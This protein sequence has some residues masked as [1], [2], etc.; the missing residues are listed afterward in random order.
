MSSASDRLRFCFF[1]LT[2][3]AIVLKKKTLEQSAPAA[4]RRGLIVVSGSSSVAHIITLRAPIV[5][6]FASPSGQSAPVVTHAVSETVAKLLPEPGLPLR[7][8][9][10]PTGS[11]FFQSHSTGRSTTSHALTTTISDATPFLSFEELNTKSFDGPA[12]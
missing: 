11:R 2:V 10:L 8:S 1:P 7:T 9:P 12:S 3:A 4:I 5:F 6:A